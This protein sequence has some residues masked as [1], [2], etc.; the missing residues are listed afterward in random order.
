MP[1]ALTH[2]RA[3]AHLFSN[4]NILIS[5]H[6][7]TLGWTNGRLDV[8][9]ATHVM[10]SPNYNPAIK[11]SFYDQCYEQITLLGSG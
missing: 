6:L 3:H 10:T 1:G 9:K 5:I 8:P 11:R 2:S 4:Q 7:H